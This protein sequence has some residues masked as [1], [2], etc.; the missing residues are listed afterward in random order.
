MYAEFKRQRL[1]NVKVHVIRY[2]TYYGGLSSDALLN[3]TAK[4]NQATSML[5]TLD[6]TT[7]WGSLSLNTPWAA[8]CAGCQQRN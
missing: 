8:R 3:W 1:E 5:L 2:Q 4:L 7:D 6:P